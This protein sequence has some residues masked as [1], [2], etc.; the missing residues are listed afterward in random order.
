MTAGVVDRLNWGPRARRELAQGP[1][2]PTQRFAGKAA[3]RPGAGMRPRE[4]NKDNPDFGAMCLDW[5]TNKRDVINK[6]NG[7]SDRMCLN[8]R[9][10]K[11]KGGGRSMRRLLSRLS[12]FGFVTVPPGARGCE[13]GCDQ[14]P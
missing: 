13:C 5:M 10:G 14:R 9:A 2:P 6:D 1:E 8:V 3:Y 11:W 12:R 4:D 7:D